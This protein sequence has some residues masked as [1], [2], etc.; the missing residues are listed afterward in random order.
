MEARRQTKPYPQQ[1]MSRNKEIIQNLY[2]AFATG[3]VATV[4]GGLTPDVHW[5]E[6][7]GGPYGGISV[8]PNA[9]LENVFMKLGAEW[10]SFSAVPADFVCEGDTVVGLGQYS[11]TYIATGKSFTA[12]FAHV[13]KLLDGKVTSFH[14]HTDTAVHL[15]PMK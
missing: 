7:Q 14:Q 5:T 12:P 10:E 15:A 6:A 4:L 3:N 11:G 1:P 8:G 13:W 9:I 2:T